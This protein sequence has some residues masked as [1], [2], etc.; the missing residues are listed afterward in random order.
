MAGNFDRLQRWVSAGGYRPVLSHNSSLPI[1]PPSTDYRQMAR[2]G[3]Q[4]WLSCPGRCWPPAPLPAADLGTARAMKWFAHIPTA[5]AE[6]SNPGTTLRISGSVSSD[7]PCLILLPK[8]LFRIRNP[9]F[10]TRPDVWRGRNPPAGSDITISHGQLCPHRPRRGSLVGAEGDRRRSGN[11]LTVPAPRDK[12]IAESIRDVIAGCWSSRRTTRDRSWAGSL[13][14][15]N[16]SQTPGFL[17]CCRQQ[18]VHLA[19]LDV[20]VPYHP[21]MEKGH[22]TVD[23]NDRLGR[24]IPIHCGYRLVT[25]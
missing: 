19:R 16:W 8:H 11:R 13:S 22:S 17:K 9:R 1:S 12:T 24:G 7:D 25:A 15:P 10:P 21:R 23:R 5:C 20:H 6:P 2:R 4:Q 18:F 3:D 14:S